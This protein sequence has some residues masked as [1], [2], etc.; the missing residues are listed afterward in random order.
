[1]LE[2]VGIQVPSQNFRDFP[3]F[4]VG[5]SRKKCP[6]ARFASTANTVCKDFG[7]FSKHLVMLS[8][9]LKQLFVLI[10]STLIC[11]CA[12]Q[13]FNLHYKCLIILVVFISFLSVLYLQL[14]IWLLMQRTKMKN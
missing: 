9:I 12:V 6:S 11:L 10:A 13:L 3:S 1:L 2:I 4:T 5:A 7:I 14:A 8:H